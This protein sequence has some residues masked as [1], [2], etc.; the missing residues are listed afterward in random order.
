[1]RAE[2]VGGLQSERDRLEATETLGRAF[3][4]PGGMER[5]VQRSLW[6]G[7]MYNP[8]HTRVAIAG[9]RVAAAVV[10][11]P[12]MIR[13][14]PVKVP[15]MTIGPVGTH[16][17][18]R[19]KGYAAAA[20]N[21]AS[22]YMKENGVLLAYLGGIENFY[23]RFGYYPC[24]TPSSVKFQRK[25]ARKEALPGSLRA[26]TRKDIPAVS[27]LYAEATSDRVC[28]AARDR[29]LW[30]WLLGPGGRSW[31]FQK[32]KLILDRRRRLCGYLTLR[33]R[34]DFAISEIVVRQDE[35]SCRAT[36]GA[37]VREMRRRELKEL[38]FRVPWDDH[39][40]VFLRQFVPAEFTIWSNPTGG[41]LMKVVDFV[42]LMKRLQPL[43]GLRWK[44]AS[45][46][47]P[48]TSFRF[49]CELGA[50]QVGLTRRQVAIGPARSGGQEVRVP[51][52]WLSG[53][54]TGHYVPQDVA[55]RKG[56]HIPSALKPSMD[57][58]FP[59]KWAFIYQGDNY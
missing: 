12:R 16:D 32:P 30:Q 2:R 11:A 55:S 45:T 5:H 6:Q 18:Y 28:A 31:L 46:A 10:M 54:L 24:L 23:Y 13:F 44:S 33:P 4:D 34:T 8:E 57:V 36:L 17:H 47:L 59:K 38:S 42:A 9:G 49:E 41:Q 7:V 27:E 48:S 56:A 19:K 35:A 39:M 21:D 52:R 37:L 25:A 1:M 29:K 43:F 50:V 53:L 20:M 58:L 14:G 40:A 22:R 51:Q 3:N 15:A 26:M